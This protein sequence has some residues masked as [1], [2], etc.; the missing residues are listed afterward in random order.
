MGSAVLLPRRL[1]S[2][3]DSRRRGVGRDALYPRHETAK[4]GTPEGR[5]IENSGLGAPEIARMQ[6]QVKRQ[7]SMKSLM[8]SRDFSLVKWFHENGVP[9]VVD[10]RRDVF[11]YD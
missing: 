9:Q 8:D 4:K 10:I 5:L 11:G 6:A 3:G 1:L 2:C 7:L